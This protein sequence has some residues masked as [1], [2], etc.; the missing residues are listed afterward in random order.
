MEKIN[1]KNSLTEYYYFQ[2]ENSFLQYHAI[3]EKS[4]FSELATHVIQ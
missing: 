2:R 3:T 1:D 4:D